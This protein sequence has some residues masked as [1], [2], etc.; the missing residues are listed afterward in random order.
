MTMY[1]LSSLIKQLPEIDQPE[2]VSPAYGVWIIRTDRLPDSIPGTLQS[3]GGWQAAS[4]DRQSLWI[5]WS[6]EVLSACA[7]INELLGKEDDKLSFQ[8]LPVKIIVGSGLDYSLSIEKQISESEFPEPDDFQIWVHTQIKK[9]SLESPAA[10]DLSGTGQW[11]LFKDS[12]PPS[13][14][15]TPAW[16]YIVKAAKTLTDSRIA[17]KWDMQKQKLKQDAEKNGLGVRYV[18]EWLV[19]YIDG[20]RQLRTWALESLS[21]FQGVKK[22]KYLSCHMLCR[23]IEDK[24]REQF[25]LAQVS[26]LNWSQ[27]EPDTLYLPLKNVFQLGTGFKMADAARVSG[28]RTIHDLAG[29]RIDRELLGE[30]EKRLDVFLPAGLTKGSHE[31]CFYCGLKCHKVQACPTRNERTLDAAGE[32]LEKKGLKEIA[33]ALEELGREISSGTALEDIIRQ[34][35]TKALVL[36]AIFAINYP[37]QHRT[38]RL[39]WRSRGSDWPQ[40]LRLLTQVEESRIWSALESLRTGQTGVAGSSARKAGFQYP[41]DYQPKT[42]QGFIALEKESHAQAESFFDE[43]ILLGYTPLHKAWHLYLKARIKEVE[44]NFARAQLLYQEALKA[45][46]QMN[47]ARY[48]QGVCMVKAGHLD[49]AFGF[50]TR[51]IREQPEYFNYIL[52]DPELGNGHG[53]FMSSLYP[54]WKKTARE[55]KSIE[56][57][58][59]KLEKKISAWFDPGLPARESLSGHLDFLRGYS[60][61]ENYVARTR[62]IS[63]C[64]KLQEDL[65]KKIEEQI[66]NLKK[67]QEALQDR[68]KTVKARVAWFPAADFFMGGFNQKAR[69]AA[70]ILKDAA[71]EDIQTASG[72]KKARKLADQAEKMIVVLEKKAGSLNTIR[73]GM[74]FILIMLK[75]FLFTFIAGLIVFFIAASGIAYLGTRYDLAWGSMILEQ[76]LD[77]FQGGIVIVLLFAVGFAAI[78]TVLVFDRKKQGYLRRKK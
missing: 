66:L 77:V 60:G 19:V 35:K 27:F 51:L 44:N 15:R 75:T 33:R 47:E 72:F 71:L 55:A 25:I 54:L 26:G 65:S 62:I 63:G 58:L 45:A 78:R 20:I 10:F 1:S 22:G 3:Y 38:I 2:L 43:A 52:I 74:L 36:R 40:G 76:K 64:K 9:L 50:M 17:G 67:E 68:L 16:I 34:S 57:L 49:Q 42:L 37:A 28:Q 5:F 70:Q 8:V 11:L 39:V 46:P 73:D 24:K 18:G 6:K 13:F 4:T 53:H 14:S 69:D 59:P 7:Q 21:V 56:E 31:T 29:V 61:I 41:R 30:M 12:K 48:R 32:Q 23:E